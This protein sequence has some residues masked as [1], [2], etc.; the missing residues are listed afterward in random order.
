MI[1][2]KYRS[3][4]REFKLEA[5][6]LAEEADKPVT[7]VAKGNGTDLF[8]VP[9]KSVPFARVPFARAVCPSCPVCLVCLPRRTQRLCWTVAARS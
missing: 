9:N 3:Y 4:S 6:R 2:K 8:G 1:R 5:I 7:Q